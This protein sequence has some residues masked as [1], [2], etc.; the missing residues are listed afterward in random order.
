M[1]GE[2]E[3]KQEQ[4]GPQASR[5][6][7][8]GLCGQWLRK[9]W[10][11]N[12]VQFSCCRNSGEEENTWSWQHQ[13]ASWRKWLQL[14][15]ALSLSSFRPLQISR[16]TWGFVWKT[17]GFYHCFGFTFFPM[18]LF[19]IHSKPEECEKGS[20]WKFNNRGRNCLG[21]DG[22]LG[23]KTFSSFLCTLFSP[24]K[25]TL[26]YSGQLR[27]THWEFKGFICP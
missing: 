1:Y 23:G 24:T 4:A 19:Y 22:S 12:R 14:V 13:E 8:R 3:K 9:L 20:E 26:P 2:L 10:C 15:V 18:T 11:P 6:G 5:V 16:H 7:K 21:N 25:N 17:L 27:Q